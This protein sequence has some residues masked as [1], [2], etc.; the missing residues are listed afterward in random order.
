MLRLFFICIVP[1][2]LPTAVFWAYRR[3]KPTAPAKKTPYLPLF[4]SGSVLTA[5][6]LCFFATNDK[7]PAFAVYTPP[8]Y[9]GGRVV[10]AKMDT[11][12]PR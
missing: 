9:T 7:A 5:L 1:F 4:L 10:P 6:F 2:F 12:H 3:F 11:S 8:K